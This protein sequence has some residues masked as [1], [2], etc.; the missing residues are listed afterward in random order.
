[1]I[2]NSKHFGHIEIPEK[3]I[4]RF[5]YGIYGFEYIKE[6]V[7][8]GKVGDDNPFIWLHAVHNPDVCFVVI[9]PFVFKKDYS[10]SI[11][12]EVL[13]KLEVEDPAD[14]RFLSIVV[15][16]QDVSRMTANLKSP[17]VINA[18]KNIA[19]QVIL[20]DEEYSTKHHILEEMKKGA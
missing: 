15:I 16:P 3:E 6:Y 12:D 8:L 20:D 14:I 11:N 1:M 13:N 5:P 10:P 17:I 2:I 19:M 18:K 9:D 7:L 4:I